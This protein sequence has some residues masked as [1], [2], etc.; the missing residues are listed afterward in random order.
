MALRRSKIDFEA[1]ATRL[2]QSFQ[3]LYLNVAEN[4]KATDLLVYSICIAYPRPLDEPL[5]LRIADFLQGLTKESCKRVAQSIL[6]HDDNLVEAYAVEWLNYQSASGYANVI[7][8]YLNRQLCQ[9]SRDLPLGPAAQQIH[10]RRQGQGVGGS[11]YKRQS[12]ESLAF[13]IW[14]ENVVEEIRLRHGNRLMLQVLEMIRVDREGGTVSPENGKAAAISLVDLCAFLDQPLALYIEEFEKPYLAQTRSYYEAEAKRF[15]RDLPPSDFLKITKERLSQEYSRCRKYL[16]RSSIDKAVREVEEQYIAKHQVRLQA[17]FAKMIAEDQHHDAS[18]T[19]DLLTRIPLGVSLL[20]DTYERFVTQS[21]RDAVARV[22]AA[23]AKNPKEYV[24]SLINLHTKYLAH[25]QDFFVNDAAFVAAID[26]AFRTIINDSRQVNPPEVIARYCDL[27][28]RKS[29]AK[30]GY[31][32]NEIEERLTQVIILFKYIDDKDVFQKFY[33]RLLAKRLIFGLSVSDDAEFN[34]ISRLKVACG[35]EY[36][37]KLQR[38]F[39]DMAL[40]HDLIAGYRE[41]RDRDGINIGVDMGIMVLTA[42]A[43]P[44]VQQQATDLQL[45]VVLERGVTAFSNFYNSKHSGRKLTW[46]WH[47]CRGEVKMVGFDKRY[48]LAA[49]L[50]QAAVLLL[51]NE[52]ESLPF[53]EIAGQT[54]LNEQELLRVLKSLVD[55]QLLTSSTGELSTAS[56]F[57]LN[58]NFTSKRT[59]LKISTV[60]QVD[61]PAENE[62]THKAVEEDRKLLAAIVRVMKSRRELGHNALVQEVI[63]QSRTRFNPSISMIKR[64]IDQLIDKQYIE[65]A[66][67]SRDVYLY[68]A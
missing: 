27:L 1:Y 60:Q 35:V 48:E 40:S 30:T 25:V 5:F 6:S 56:N 32:D 23:L 4:V 31:S 57:A 49:S 44:I 43:W 14:R 62:T 13:M 33:S 3:C 21:G 28:L 2:L 12:I 59:K 51:Y 22:V 39:T 42:G 36:T 38:M 20:V 61:T 15:I 47:L 66:P 11:H 8:E 9:P 24:D 63:E 18:M 53:K 65:R 26:K 67:N 34:M 37:S 29:A 10:D 52:R 55:A 64:C 54:R 41:R 58:H 16:H 68:V 17:E 7:C 46:M 19:Y 50:H 45:P